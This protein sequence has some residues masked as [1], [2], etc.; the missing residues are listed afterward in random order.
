MFELLLEKGNL[1]NTG[2]V[3]ERVIGFVNGLLVRGYGVLSALRHGLGVEVL[4]L[5]L[6]L[7]EHNAFVVRRLLDLAQS[8]LQAVLL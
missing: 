5:F 7:K 2:L 3:L 6:H 1:H 8:L 4:E